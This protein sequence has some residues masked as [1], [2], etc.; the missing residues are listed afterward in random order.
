MPED[1]WSHE[2]INYIHRNTYLYILPTFKNFQFNNLCFMVSIFND[3]FSHTFP[4]LQ[5][6]QDLYNLP[7]HTPL[8]TVRDTLFP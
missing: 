8:F 3:S 1:K 2:D 7:Y 5:G 4:S 6:F